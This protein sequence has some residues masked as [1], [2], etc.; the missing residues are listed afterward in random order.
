MKAIWIA[1]AGLLAL[2][3]A[4]VSRLK[5]LAKE[6][7]FTVSANFQNLSSRGVD[8]VCNITIKNP[9]AGEITL[10]HPSISVFGSQADAENN[11]QTP[12]KASI[13]ESKT[14]R[15][16]KNAETVVGPVVIQLTPLDLLPGG[17]GFALL[18]RLYNAA[19]QG[20]SAQMLVRTTITANGMRQKA[21][22]QNITIPAVKLGRRKQI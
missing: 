9:T 12:L 1:G 19:I 5:S 18:S 16:Q 11:P 3:I 14:Y 17:V 10:G 15:V 13:P 8:L 21:I 22:I 6:F 7:T 4:R 20:K 2:G